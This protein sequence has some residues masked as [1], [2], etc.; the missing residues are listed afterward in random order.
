MTQEVGKCAAYYTVSF[1]VQGMLSGCFPGLSQSCCF[2]CPVLL[3]QASS[4][5]RQSLSCNPQ[6]FI[7]FFLTYRPSFIIFQPNGKSRH[8][9]FPS[10]AL[11]LPALLTDCLSQPL[12]P[13]QVVYMSF[14]REIRSE[15]KMKA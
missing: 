10:I 13:C 8:K 14:C 11:F 9:T 15:W 4:P 12:V 6:L 7:F 5:L 2:F 1:L 3:I